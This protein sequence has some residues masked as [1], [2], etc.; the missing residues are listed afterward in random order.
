[1]VVT[2]L[3]ASEASFLV[4]SMH[5]IFSIYIYRISSI[6]RRLLINAGPL[7]NAGYKR[8]SASINAGSLL[9]AGSGGGVAQYPRG[10]YHS[11]IICLLVRTKY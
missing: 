7:I 5:R 9:N 10:D 4:S 6:K 1:M 11:A 3:I 8:T 2:L